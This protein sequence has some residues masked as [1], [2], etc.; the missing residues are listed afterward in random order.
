[1]LLWMEDPSGGGVT[2]LIDAMVRLLLLRR[3]WFHRPSSGV[4]LTISATAVK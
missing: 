4:A 2:L 3:C 1:M